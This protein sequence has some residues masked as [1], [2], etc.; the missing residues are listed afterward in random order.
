MREEYDFSKGKR[1]KNIP[2]LAKLQS[3]KKGKTRITIMLDNSVIDNFRLKAKQE[4]LDYQTLINQVLKACSTSTAFNES[5]L[6][7]TIQKELKN[8]K[9]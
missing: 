9:A 3:E 6:Q 5:F 7:K 4:G 2:H 1:A 8:A